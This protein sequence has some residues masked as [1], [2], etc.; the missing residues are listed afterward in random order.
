M[1]RFI[2][3]ASYGA[4]AS[5]I[6]NCFIFKVSRAVRGCIS[7][8]STNTAYPVYSAMDIS[9]LLHES[10][11]FV[12]VTI[13]LFFLSIIFCAPLTPNAGDAAGKVDCHP[14]DEYQFTMI[15]D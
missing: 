10:I 11:I 12:Y 2:G 4:L 1:I 8:K 9:C 5:S 7:S 6:S 3:V 15:D 13:K 14:G